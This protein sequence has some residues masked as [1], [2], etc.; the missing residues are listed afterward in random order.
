MNEKIA[1]PLHKVH[2]WRVGCP[3]GGHV[4]IASGVIGAF[5]SARCATCKTPLPLD[6]ITPVLN[7]VKKLSLNRESKL[8]AL[9]LLG[10][11]DEAK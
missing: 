2:A 5:E 7:A 4:D 6:D 10:R 3:C 1:V 9:I 8:S 11:C